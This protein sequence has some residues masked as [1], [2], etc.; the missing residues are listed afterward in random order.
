MSTGVHYQRE[1]TVAPTNNQFANPQSYA[2]Q[3]V[4]VPLAYVAAQAELPSQ[5]MS[6][7]TAAMLNMPNVANVQTQIKFDM[8]EA[9]MTGRQF[10]GEGYEDE[11]TVKT[12]RG[13][14]ITTSVSEMVGSETIASGEGG[15]ILDHYN[16]FI[17]DIDSSVVV[18]TSAHRL[19]IWLPKASSE[20]HCRTT[21]FAVNL[22]A[23]DFAQ[24]GKGK[25]E[26]HEEIN[27]AVDELS[28]EE[29][30]GVQGVIE[31]F[32]QVTAKHSEIAESELSGYLEQGKSWDFTPCSNP[33]IQKVTWEKVVSKLPQ[34]NVGITFS[35]EKGSGQSKLNRIKYQRNGMSEFFQIIAEPNMSTS[36]TSDSLHH[37]GA[38]LK[39]NNY[40]EHN[41]FIVNG[42]CK[43][44]TTDPKEYI[45][46]VKLHDL[47]ILWGLQNMQML[48]P[49]YVDVVS[50]WNEVSS[51]ITKVGQEQINVA[52]KKENVTNVM[53]ALARIEEDSDLKLGEKISAVL[54]VMAKLYMANTVNAAKMWK[55]DTT[56]GDPHYVIPAAFH[57]LIHKHYTDKLNEQKV[58]NSGTLLTLKAYALPCTDDARLDADDTVNS[59]LVQFR[60]KGYYPQ[61]GYCYLRLEYK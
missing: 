30:K 40:A 42:Q 48:F 11:E 25:G 44:L 34:H 43:D 50:K 1:L 35:E 45:R 33:V 27:L 26:K 4:V 7:S 56:G 22:E 16:K 2:S 32:V 37:P 6:D 39:S 52:K 24:K 36:V 14:K 55:L 5:F 28:R 19:T 53:N 31:K 57:V 58:F 3:N 21:Q 8:A 54:T 49:L 13:K 17:I 29:L 12:F 51:S 23:N 41:P 10:H 18:D 38:L 47:D 59:V 9:N 15:G 61:L 46:R 20:V 60:V